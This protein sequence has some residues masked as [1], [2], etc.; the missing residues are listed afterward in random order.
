[1]N[2]NGDESTVG[3]LARGR[4]LLAAGWSR[5]AIGWIDPHLSCEG[6]GN[7]EFRVS[8]VPNRQYHETTR[9]WS[10]TWVTTLSDLARP[11]ARGA[12]RRQ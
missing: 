10:L 8:S 11:P 5:T 6:V 12:V 9:H 3:H 4:N 1:M 7:E 2:A